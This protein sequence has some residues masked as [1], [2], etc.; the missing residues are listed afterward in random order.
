MT[1]S[2][3]TFLF[4]NIVLKIEQIS[5]I[6]TYFRLH[7]TLLYNL[8]DYIL[9]SVFFQLYLYSTSICCALHHTTEHVFGSVAEFI[10]ISTVA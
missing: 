8:G 3:G 10:Q 2:K 6:D 7:N 4:G 9:P 5:L 1:T